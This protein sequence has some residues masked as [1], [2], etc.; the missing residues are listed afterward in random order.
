MS[1]ALWGLALFELAR[2]V[3]LLRSRGGTLE[4][5]MSRMSLD[6]MLRARRYA[7]NFIVL[8]CVAGVVASVPK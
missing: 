6:E 1:L 8:S 7:L 5:S 4:E 3:V 2:F